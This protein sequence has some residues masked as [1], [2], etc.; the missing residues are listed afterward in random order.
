MGIFSKLFGKSAGIPSQQGMGDKVKRVS[1][2][3]WEVTKPLPIEIGAP[4]QPPSEEILATMRTALMSSG[5]LTVYWFWVSINGDRPHLGLA[6]APRNDEVVSRV[7]RAIEP[8]WTQYSPD[9]PLF[10]ILRLDGSET[11][12]TITRHGKLLCGSNA[13]PN[14]MET[15]LQKTHR[16]RSHLPELV[17]TL[18]AGHVYIIAWWDDP[19]SNKISFQDFVNNGKSFIA[20]FSDEDHF[21]NE[22]RGYDL[23]KKKGVSID[24]NLFASILTGSE[25][26]ILNPGSKTPIEISASELKRYVDESRL[27]Q[28]P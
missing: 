19:K 26:L 8:I 20:I 3:T 6:V 27:P 1:D 2:H 17:Q 18:M 22:T 5:A 14:T 10:D 23:A 7:G 12:L 21:K 9:N 4:A 25:L 13:K 15:L 11:D 28:S 24:A 16:D